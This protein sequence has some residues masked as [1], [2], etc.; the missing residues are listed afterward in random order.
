MNKPYADIND[1][2][3]TDKDVKNFKN[4][5]EIKQNI[6]N[7]F[8]NIP[9]KLKYHEPLHYME[10]QFQINARNELIFEDG[11]F[12]DAFK[13]HQKGFEKSIGKIDFYHKKINPRIDIMNKRKAEC[14]IFAPK[15]KTNTEICGY[16]PAPHSG[17]FV[18]YAE[19]PKYIDQ[20][21]KSL[22][23]INPIDHYFNYMSDEKQS[24]EHIV[25]PFPRGGYDTRHLNKSL[26]NC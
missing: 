19:P 20:R 4:E 8:I 18:F 14:H 26:K 15:E 6:K 11:S 2:L 13:E 17:N 16:I 1:F 5:Y 22:G 7:K 25:L 10:E 12:C 21:S 23:Y 24:P 9:P 3:L